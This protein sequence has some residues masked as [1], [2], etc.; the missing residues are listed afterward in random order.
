MNKRLITG[1]KRI[2]PNKRAKEIKQA[3]WWAILFTRS[4]FEVSQNGR[5]CPKISTRR[6]YR[7]LI[8]SA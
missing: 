7:R 6:T 2:V 4:L 5:K 3:D 1:N 8:E